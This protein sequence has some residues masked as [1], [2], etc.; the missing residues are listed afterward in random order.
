LNEAIHYDAIIVGGGPAGLSAA[1]V[2]GRCRRRVLVCDTGS[3]RNAAS[4][5][6]HGFVTRDGV[7]P[8]EFLQIARAE[9]EQYAVEVLAREVVAAEPEAG[10]FAVT[11]GDGRTLRCRK[12]LLAT[13]V[14]DQIPEIPGARE[15]YGR[16]VYHCPYCDGWEVRDQPVAVYG[17]GVDAAKL[18]LGLTTWT[19][20]VALLTGGK[21]RLRPERR[22]RLARNGVAV[23][24]DR[25]VALEGREDI[26]ERVVFASGEPLPRRAL[27]FRTGQHQRSRLAEKLG[28]A[29]NRKGTVTTNRLSGTCV[30]G[31]FCAGDASDDVQLVIV[32]AAEGAKAAFAINHEL[33]REDL[34]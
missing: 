5:G 26:L 22:A 10:G 24:E 17:P 16:G 25:I 1:L 11:L 12:L 32:A 15:M 18:A 28:C 14:V 9:L 34:A 27:F 13:G 31:V 6:L 4:R 2:L 19:R 8:Q 3:P 21:S 29:L 7:L 30:P 33:Q 20:D 23:R